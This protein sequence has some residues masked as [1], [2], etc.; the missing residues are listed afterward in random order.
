[1]RPRQIEIDAPT[2]AGINARGVIL[3]FLS[4]E[5]DDGTPDAPAA[6]IV[7]WRGSVRSESNSGRSYHVV[8]YDDHTGRCSCADYHFRGV[9]KDDRGYACKHIRTVR[10]R[11]KSQ[12]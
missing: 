9:L 12:A 3:G 11:L 2:Q 10:L 8:I 4:A 5:S 7:I 1:V 6:P